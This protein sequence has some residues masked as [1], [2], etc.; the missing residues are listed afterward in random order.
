MEKTNEKF[1]DI[2]IKDAIERD[3]AKSIKF[4][5]AKSKNPLSLKSVMSDYSY[6]SSQMTSS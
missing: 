5:I 6:S 1:R 4:R 2:A 3:K